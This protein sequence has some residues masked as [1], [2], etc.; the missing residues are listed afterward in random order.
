MHVRSANAYLS[1]GGGKRAA[2]AADEVG[3]RVK[4]R[5]ENSGEAR[6]GGHRESS[7]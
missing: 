6:S 4:L 1:A 3:Q 7:R 5:V 2:A